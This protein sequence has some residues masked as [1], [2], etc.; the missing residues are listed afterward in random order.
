MAN[1]CYLKSQI[2]KSRSFLKMTAMS[3]SPE[4]AGPVSFHLPIASTHH[5]PVTLI[6][7]QSGLTMHYS[8]MLSPFGH[9]IIMKHQ[10]RLAGLAF[11]NNEA[12]KAALLDFKQRWPWFAFQDNNN[13]IGHAERMLFAP[14]QWNTMAPLAITLIGTDFEHCVWSALM[15]IPLADTTHYQDIAKKIGKPKASRAVG[16]AVGRNPLAFIVPCHRVI[17]ATGAL[18]GYHWGLERKKAMLNWE[19]NQRHDEHSYA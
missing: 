18:T 19:C 17:G 16:R 12:Q 10:G 8:W 11:A 2:I 9:A 13:I 15:A 6:R 4:L 14:D 5:I 1:V 3:H 7:K